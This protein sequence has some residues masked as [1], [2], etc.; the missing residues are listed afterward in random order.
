MRVFVFSL[1]ALAVSATLAIA[2]PSGDPAR[3]AKVYERCGACHS[4]DANRAGPRHR[5]LFGR[6][7]GTVPGFAYSPA[8]KLAN[9]VWSEETLERFLA[10]PLKLVPGTRMYVSVPDPQERADLIAYLRSAAQ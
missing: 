2:A 1:P 5:G 8:M 9:L 4:L 6:K 10:D 3:G 7:A